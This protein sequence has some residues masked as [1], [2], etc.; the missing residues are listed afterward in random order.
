M[1]RF[2][3]LDLTVLHHVLG[4]V[5]WPTFAL[6]LHDRLQFIYEAREARKN[7][8]E[9]RAETVGRIAEE[10]EYKRLLETE[11]T[12]RKVEGA[13]VLAVKQRL[14]V[15]EVARKQRELQA[16]KQKIGEEEAAT[17][18]FLEN[19]KRCLSCRVYLERIE[20]CPHMISD[21]LD[22]GIWVI[23]DISDCLGRRKASPIE[24]VIYS[25]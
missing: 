21:L 11:E 24:L 2:L 5:L 4:V 8:F 20:G 18:V 10:R 17:K 15:E 23:E 22:L 16:L 14:E 7:A 9:D 1:G 25:G 12:A 3:A 13:Q 19:M 6:V